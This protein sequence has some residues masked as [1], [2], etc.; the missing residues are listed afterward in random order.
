MTRY[1]GRV[2]ILVTGA[3]G[4]IGSHLT[5]ALLRRGHDV[6][7]FVQYT[8]MGSLGW[9]DDLE[10]DLR[11]RIRV[12]LGDVRDAAIVRD[13]LT[14]V[15]AVAHLAALISVPYSFTATRSFVDTNALG[16]LNVVEAAIEAGVGRVLIM[17]TSEV[18]GTA[19]V[20]PMDESHR[21]HAQSPYA[22]SK[23]S[24]EKLAESLSLSRDADIV[25]ARGFNTFGPRQSTRAVVGTILQQVAAGERELQLGATLTRRDLN[26]VSDVTEALSLLL[27]SKASFRADVF[28]IATGASVS[29]EELV[30]TVATVVGHELTIVSRQDLLRPSDVDVL[31]GDA[32]KLR[33]ATGWRPTVDLFEGLTRT[34]AW[35][36]SENRIPHPGV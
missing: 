28:N 14:G 27:E 2:R 7:S 18:Y 36:Q 20:V 24:A 12:V 33:E 21:L 13:A 17:S 31:E 29:I 30:S 25:I 16:T 34:H 4:F 32:T 9:L 23:I 3:E 11:A 26:F 1:H 10:P 8:S 22:A 5:E 15:T 19:V 6:V 35:W